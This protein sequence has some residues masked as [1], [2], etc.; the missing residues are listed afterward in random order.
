MQSCCW[1][2]DMLMSLARTTLRYGNLLLHS[3]QKMYLVDTVMSMAS[4]EKGSGGTRVDV[5]AECQTGCRMAGWRCNEGMLTALG[6]VVRS[7]YR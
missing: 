3:F 6:E 4:S 1:S 7:C 2:L 5:V